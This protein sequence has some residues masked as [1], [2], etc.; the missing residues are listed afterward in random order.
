MHSHMRA[1][2]ASESARADH[3]GDGG[4]DGLRVE[5]FGGENL[6][7]AEMRRTIEDRIPAAAANLFG[8]GRRNGYRGGE[9]LPEAGH[10]PRQYSRRVRC[11]SGRPDR[12]PVRP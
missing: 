8:G 11:G 6:L 1:T 9:R 10:M 5:G 4:T 7:P 3:G 2:A 12:N